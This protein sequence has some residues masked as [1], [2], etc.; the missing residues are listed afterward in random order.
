MPGHEI[1]LR[2]TSELR[3][4]PLLGRLLRQPAQPV[5]EV[6][7][8]DASGGLVISERTVSPGSVLLRHAGVH[9]TDS[10]DWTVAADALRDGGD[11]GWVTDPYRPR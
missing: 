7:V 2:R 1:R 5:Y 9:T 8:R 6:E 4:P 10:H 11:P 3:P